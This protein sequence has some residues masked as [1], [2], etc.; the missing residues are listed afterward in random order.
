MGASVTIPSSTTTQKV[1]TNVEL[2]AALASGILSAI[3]ATA[4]EG[5]LIGPLAV[6]VANAVQ[7]Y[8]QATGVPVTVESLKLLYPSMTP[9]VPP[10]S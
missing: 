1:L 2:I 10:K 9:L 3:P 7:S 8:E 5:A 6:L 4:P